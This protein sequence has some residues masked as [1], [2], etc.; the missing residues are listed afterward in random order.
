MGGRGKGSV[1]FYGMAFM[2]KEDAAPGI[3]GAIPSD[4]DILS[5]PPPLSPLLFP[6]DAWEG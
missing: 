2:Y 6:A 3:I 1:W 4:V 5:V